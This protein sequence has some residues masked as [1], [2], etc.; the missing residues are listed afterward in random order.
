MLVLRGLRAEGLCS[1]AVGGAGLS[2]LTLV[3]LWVFLMSEYWV[4][5]NSVL[6]MGDPLCDVCTCHTLLSSASPCACADRDLQQ[7]GGL[8]QCLWVLHPMVPPLPPT[9]PLSTSLQ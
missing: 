3:I 8:G 1:V 5:F 4:C 9:P 6:V 2:C 7:W